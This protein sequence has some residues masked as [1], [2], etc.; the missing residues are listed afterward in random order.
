MIEN[1]IVRL[2]VPGLRSFRS[3]LAVF[4]LLLSCLW[5]LACPVTGNA[6]ETAV[7]TNPEHQFKDAQDLF[8]KGLYADAQPLFRKTIDEIGYFTQTNRQLMLQDAQYYY[9]MCALELEQP[10]AEALAQKYLSKTDN[11]ARRQLTA[12]QLAR[13]YYRQNKLSEAIPYY[14]QAGFDNLSND[15]VAR[16]KFELG[17][18]YFNL[19]RFKDAQPLFKAIRDIH[20]QYYIPANY[21]YG[22]IA[23]YDK[24][25][26]DALESFQR[27][28]GQPKYDVIVPY[29]IAEIYYYQNKPDKLL[30]YAQPYLESGKLYY[31][32]DLKH[33]VGQTYFEQKNYSKALPYLEAYES[34]AA[35]LQKEDVYEL[36]YCYYQTNNLPKAIAG[37]KQ[38]SGTN[39]SLG[40]NSMYLLG[41]CY[42]KT[43]QKAEARNAFAFCARS[44]YNLKQQEISRF[45]YGKLSYELGY[46]DAALNTLKQFISDYPQSSYGSEAREILAHLFMNTDDYKNALAVV[47]A[48]PEKTPEVQRAYQRITFGRAIQL[49]NDGS[50]GE[51]DQMLGNSLK[52][53]VDKQLQQLASFWKGEIALRQGNA[54]QAIQWTNQYL[55]LGGPAPAALGEANEQTAHYNLGYSLL[56]KQQYAEALQQF[57]AAQQ[58]FGTNGTQIANDATLRAADCYYMMKDYQHAQTLYN[59][60]IASGQPGSDYALYQKGIISGVTGDN[61][62]KVNIMQQLSRQYPA[63]S[64]SSDADYQ[65]ATTYMAEEQYAQA[66][67]Y[68]NKVIAQP[69]NPDAPKALLKLGLAYY[70]MNNQS[71]AIETYKKVVTE[72]PN[73][74]QANEAVQ[75]LRSLYVS[76]GN[77]DAYLDFLK[78][79]GHSVSASAEDSITYAAGESSFGNAAYAAAITQLNNYLSKFP[80]GRFILN[81]HFYLAESQYNQKDYPNALTNY[82]YVLS[83]GNTQFDERSAAQAAR[84]SFYQNKDYS[85]A[86]E[87]FSRLKQLST[88]KE[89]T[90]D[91]LRGILRC[92][93]ELSQWPAVAGS[94]NDLLGSTN[95]STDDQIVGHFYLARAQQTQN[96]CDSAVI[97]YQIVAQMT[98]SELGAESRYYIGECRLSQNDLKGAETA[99]Y[100]VIKNTPSYDYWVA[101]AY[102]MLGDIFWKN[103]DY[104]NAKATLQSIVDNCKIP[105][106]VNQAKDALAKVVADEKTHSKIK[107]TSSGQTTGQQ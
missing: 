63:S 30:S 103:K 98:K 11:N 35:A 78:S 97:N 5:L 104:F 2:L 28:V 77:P 25:Y 71:Q 72:F 36:A 17:Y 14:E 64:Y 107:D 45:N 29:Y 91:A 101:S 6:Q 61:S 32:D 73:S 88:S 76:A 100:D 79:T 85:R 38:L 67:P 43:G 33:L 12:Y 99:A 96:K 69:H 40:Q 92:N 94:A 54:D 46:Q 3:T 80:Q 74:P 60:A 27:V 15:E 9:D 53:P 24:N 26:S 7:Y 19:K 95:I 83:Q 16:A 66:I 87:Y 13:Y 23:Y 82:A 51:A 55:S 42:L 20:N 75:S 47:E 65:I 90:L 31:N 18:C 10:N 59:S 4:T 49:I 57:Q 34:G 50:L 37:F 62:Q 39:D 105:E 93:Y 1:K 8:Q 41:D 84:I 102:I 44:S 58:A 68:L 106:L 81:A 22:F 86:L 52:N 70:N 56:K 21:Y 89:N 48:I